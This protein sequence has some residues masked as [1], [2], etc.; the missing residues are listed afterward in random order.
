M[1]NN[2]NRIHI[3]LMTLYTFLCEFILAPYQ[4][5]TFRETN[6]QS[7]EYIECCWNVN[8]LKEIGIPL[9]RL[10]FL[11]ATQRSCH[12]AIASDDNHINISGQVPIRINF[13][14]AYPLQ[15]RQLLLHFDAVALL[16]AHLCQRISGC[17]Q[18]E[19]LLAFI[20]EYV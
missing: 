4:D 18:L 19:I 17:M 12:D 3:R 6:R 5:A 10:R 20:Q 7:V 11:L 2:D 16:E 14:C 13:K 8:I 15:L 9:N 1:T